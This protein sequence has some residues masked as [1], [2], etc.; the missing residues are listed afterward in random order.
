[1]PRNFKC[2]RKQSL[3]NNFNVTKL[4]KV[5]GR[6]YLVKTWAT[7]KNCVQKRRTNIFMLRSREGKIC[8]SH[9][10]ELGQCEKA[11]RAQQEM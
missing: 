2:F 9:A 8:I 5:A 3:D 7:S 10:H 11:V 4:I 1:M 6:K